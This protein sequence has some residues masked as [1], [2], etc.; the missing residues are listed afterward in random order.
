[1]K[2]AEQ[3]WFDKLEIELERMEMDDHIKGCEDH[4]SHHGSRMAI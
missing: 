3:D 2:D 1:V 4:S